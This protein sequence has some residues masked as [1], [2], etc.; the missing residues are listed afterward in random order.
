MAQLSVD[1]GGFTFDVADEG[2]SDRPAVL[3][4]HGFPQ[5]HSCWDDWVTPL[6]QAGFRVIRPDQR[7]YSPRA[8]PLTVDAYDMRHLVEDAFDIL[9]ARGVRRCHVIGHDWGGAVAWAM[10]SQRPGDVL[11]LTVLSTPY[12]SAL[13]AAM[14]RSRQGLMSWYMAAF[15]VPNVAERL[16]GPDG[17]MWP[18]FTAGLPTSAQARYTDRARQPGAFTAMVQWYRA[19]ARETVRPS[20]DWHRITVPT[21]YA[22]GRRDPALGSAAAQATSDYVVG[23]YRFIVLS[24]HGHWL[25]ERAWDVLRSPVLEHLATASDR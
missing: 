25:P 4:L 18:W 9:S 17:P 10:A 22:W 13:T 8:R 3:L 14:R 12:P 11:S 2:A 6:T 15:Q 24:R 20:I 19:M 23:P 21:L 1:V 5:D 7:G 16:A